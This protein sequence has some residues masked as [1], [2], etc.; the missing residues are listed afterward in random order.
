MEVLYFG[1]GFCRPDD[2]SYSLMFLVL[3]A[4]AF[5]LRWPVNDFWSFA[6]G[7]FKVL[8]LLS[9]SPFCY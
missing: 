9:F 2:D 5:D 3:S 7:G 6:T 4:F 1:F 8:S